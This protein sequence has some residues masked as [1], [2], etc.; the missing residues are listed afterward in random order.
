MQGNRVVIVQ[1]A[2]KLERKKVDFPG[3]GSAWYMVGVLFL[4]S[5]LSNIPEIVTG[6]F[7]LGISDGFSTLI[8]IRGKRKLSYNKKKT[9]EGSIAFFVTALFT[10]VWIGWFAIPLAFL[11]SIAEGLNL[12]MDDNI[13]V[14][15][16]TVVFLL[17]V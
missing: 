7:L 4:V 15:F 1:M 6:I 10:Y 11:A 9:W 17:L 3:Y 8:G 13:V 2:E 5:F 16:V 14:P 12:P